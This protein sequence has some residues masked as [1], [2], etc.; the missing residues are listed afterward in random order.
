MMVQQKDTQF[1]INMKKSIIGVLILLFTIASKKDCYS[2]NSKEYDITMLLYAALT[3][4]YNTKI[5]KKDVDFVSFAIKIDLEYSK[6]KLKTPI[7]STNDTISKSLF[8]NLENLLSKLDYTGICNANKPKLT[9][10]LPVAIFATGLERT[11]ALTQISVL[12][13]QD[14]ISKM[15]YFERYNEKISKVSFLSPFFLDTARG[16]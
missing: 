6:N 5:I 12:E 9:L 10:I 3:D 2:Q 11:P 13:I 15:Y 14:K 16:Y 8:P 7:V 4:D 1:V